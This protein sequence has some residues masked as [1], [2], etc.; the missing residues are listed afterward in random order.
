[1]E[2]AP[3][4]RRVAL[5]PELVSR[6]SQKGFDVLVERDAGKAASFPDA[7]FA[8]AG[9]RLVDAVWADAILAAAGIVDDGDGDPT[10]KRGDGSEARGGRVIRPPRLR[11]ATAAHRPRAGGRTRESFPAAMRGARDRP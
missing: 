5:V 7:A 3:G 1:M 11:S 6:L 4:E 10:F 9:A 8:E 2:H